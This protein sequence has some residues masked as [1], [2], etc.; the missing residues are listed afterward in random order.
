MDRKAIRF[1]GFTIFPS[2]ENVGTPVEQ[3]LTGP[4]EFRDVI[5]R[6]PPGKTTVSVWIYPDSYAEYNRLKSWLYEQHYQIACWPLA[7]G[8]HI[9]GGPNG[10]RTSAQ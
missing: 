3:S 4:S 8:K 1:D 5:R 2:S 9:S 7:A 6:F 10:L